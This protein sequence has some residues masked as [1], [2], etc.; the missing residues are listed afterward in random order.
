MET[1][2]L[3]ETERSDRSFNMGEEFMM[4]FYML[5]AD[6]ETCRRDKAFHPSPKIFLTKTCWTDVQPPSC[7]GIE[8]QTTP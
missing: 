5:L 1:V 6:S 4:L 7:R 2:C 3:Y 8:F